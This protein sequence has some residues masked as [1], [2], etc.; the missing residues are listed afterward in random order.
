MIKIFFVAANMICL[1]VFVLT[2]Q[3]GTVEET[4][5]RANYAY[6]KADFSEALAL[7]DSIKYKGVAV[8]SNMG[9]CYF[10]KGKVPE[11]ILYWL[12]AQKIADINDFITIQS[13]I[14]NALDKQGVRHSK[15]SEI[16]MLASR[17]LSLW[18]WQLLFLFFW[19]VLILRYSYLKRQRRY[20][21]A[22]LLLLLVLTIG[23]MCA[24]AYNYQQH[25]RGIIIKPSISVFAGP[26]KDYVKLAQASEL[27]VL[28]VYQQ[29]NH[30]LKV[31]IP[32]KGLGW[33]QEAD[34]AML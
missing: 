17:L 26:G 11:A 14:N 15:I 23:T 33:I 16:L 1:S 32:Q 10:H 3:A 4:F 7:Y 13:Y 31:Y 6:N 19:F 18:A 2:L 22:C 29:R 21:I 8:L 34:L 12:R 28:R 5:L 30:W 25:M 27:L 24:W 9:N 20:S